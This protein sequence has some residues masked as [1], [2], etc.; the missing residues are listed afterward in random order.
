[1]PFFT[2]S[3]GTKLAY[4]DEGR[5]IPVLCL[6]GLTRNMADFD[7]VAPHLPDCRLIRM[8]Y[9]GRGQSDWTG[10]ATYT[11]PQ[12]GRDALELLDHLG[13]DRV[14]VLGTS[15][16][17]LVGMWL[18]QAAHDRLSG[19]C[20]NDIGPVI[21][22][23]GLDRIFHYIGR[24]PT[25][26]SYQAVADLMPELV[27]G[28]SDVPPG[29]WLT[30]AHRH[31]HATPQG[32]ANNYD[33][34]LRDSFVDAFKLIDQ[35]G[36][37]L[38]RATGDLPVAVIRGV[39]SDLLSADTVDQMHQIRPDLIVAA[40]PGRAHIPWLDEAESLAAIRAWLDAVAR[41]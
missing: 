17:G 24:N 34:A 10:A 32:L 14:A 11:I 40:V 30:D 27:Q 15:R 29:R 2:T 16:G 7:Y 28:F 13:L 26:P 6:A 23:A 8:D 3:D 12:E 9:R 22:R 39:N 5:G 36:W 35:D 25:L 41:L 21:D 4:S 19:L 31:F 1:M 38:W 18:A 37:A 33:P 20:L